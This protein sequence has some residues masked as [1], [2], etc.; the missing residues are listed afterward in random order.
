[1]VA[2]RLP[3]RW[4]ENRGAQTS[5]RPPCSTTRASPTWPKAK[6]SATSPRP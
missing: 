3:N 1:M 6:R 2:T 5:R 4:G